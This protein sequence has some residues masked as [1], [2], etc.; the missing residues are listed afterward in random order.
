[1]QKI[2]FTA[3]FIFICIVLN[4]QKTDIYKRPVIHERDRDFDAI[5]YSINLDVDLNEKKL[6]GKNTITL[7]PLRDNLE[8]VTL[9]AVSLHVTDVFDSNGK[10]LLFE[11]TKDQLRIDLSRPCSIT[12][13]TMR[14]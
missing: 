9:D 12:P 7:S 10:P 13:G 6:T 4:A 3:L 5:H 8:K 1:M 14:R 2:S 11:Q